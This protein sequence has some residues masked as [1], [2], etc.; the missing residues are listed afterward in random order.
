MLLF[1]IHLNFA[2]VQRLVLWLALKHDTSEKPQKNKKSNLY[3]LWKLNKFVAC[4]QR[5]NPSKL[6]E[7]YHNEL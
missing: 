7:P 1:G 2:A 3:T 4:K 5:T 6:A